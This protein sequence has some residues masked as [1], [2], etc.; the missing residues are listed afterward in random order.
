MGNILQNWVENTNM[1]DSIK[2][3]RQ[4]PFTGSFFHMTIFCLGVSIVITSMKRPFFNSPAS[5]FNVWPK[6]RDISSNSVHEVKQKLQERKI[7]KLPCLKF[8]KGMLPAAGCQA[9]AAAAVVDGANEA[10]C[11][12]N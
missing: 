3:L 11:P 2:H 4:S 10:A 8:E 1:T 9:A 5:I 12:A 6:W 7:K